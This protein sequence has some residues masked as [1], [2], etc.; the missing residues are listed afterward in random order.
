VSPA[1]KE[2]L[3]AVA[4]AVAKGISDSQP[5][6]KVILDAQGVAPEQDKKPWWKSSVP[7]WVTGSL[8]GGVLGVGI[9][10]GGMQVANAE[11]DKRIEVT[12]KK[13]D[14]T[15][16]QVRAVEVAASERLHVVE[17]KAAALEAG[18]AAQHV[19][20]ADKVDEVKQDVADVKKDTQDLKLK[21]EQ[22][23]AAVKKL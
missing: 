10:W 9:A 17:L 7:A 18:N 8:L 21:L 20:L 14:A 4:A 6:H 22:V 13:A 1:S 12:T 3:E 16:E 5:P 23:L 19:A 2:E 15:A 11:Q